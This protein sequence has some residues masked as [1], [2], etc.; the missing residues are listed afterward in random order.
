MATA[1]GFALVVPADWVPGPQQGQWTYEDYAAIPED[2]HRYE[3][4]NGVLYMSPAPNLGHQGSVGRFNYYLLTYVEFVGRGRVFTGPVDVE[5]S[6]K[7]VVQPDV[8]VVL[9]KHLDRLRKTRIIGAPDLIIEIASPSTVHHDQHAKLDAYAS[10]GVPEYWMVNPNAQTVK[11]LIVENDVY[12]SLGL[13]S[14]QATLPSQV[15][16]DL[17]VRVEQFFSK[18]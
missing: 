13:F 9:K 7:N 16:P 4:V 10:A 17:P 18:S 3:V 11:V 1:E 14:G 2:G 6:Y 12:R 5:L 8:L 15:L